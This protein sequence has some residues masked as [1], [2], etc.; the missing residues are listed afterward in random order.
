MVDIL[1]QLWEKFK[2]SLVSVLPVTFIILILAIT[3]FINLSSKEIV[4]FIITAILL[5]IGISLFNLGA[6]IALSPMGEYIGESLV[7]TKKII[8]LIV[9][10]FVMGVLTTIAEPDL[11]VLAEQVSKLVNN[12]VLIISVGIGVGVFLVF[13]ILK[14]VFKK[15][16]TQILMFF[17]MLLFA[18]C[19]LMAEFGKGSYIPLSFDS[20]GV[21]TGPITVPFLMALGLGVALSI[22]GKDKKNASFGIIALCSIG[23]IMAVAILMLTSN[24]DMKYTLD[25]YSLETYLNSFGEL[26]LEHIKDVA[27]SL[28]L[29]IVFFFV[30]NFTIIKLPKAKIFRILIG[31]LYTFVGLVIFLVSVNIG[32][33][34][35]GYKIGNELASNKVVLIIFAFLLGLVAVLAEPAVHV[36][37]KQVEET[38][39]GMITKTQMTIALSIGVGISICLSF[40]RILYGFSILYYII[41]GYIISL[42]LSLFVP[43]IYTSIAFDSGG[44]A[45]GP[46]TSS[47][48]LPMAIGACL[49]L[50]GEE[51]IMNFAFGLVAMVAMTPLIT[52]Q[53][54]GFRG[55]MRDRNKTRRTIRTIIS[56]DDNQ[57]I[58]F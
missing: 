13:A 15:D 36:L 4:V 58:Y 41:P 11:S 48:I 31:L 28:G 24:G 7:K 14:I 55:L 30:L 29:L 44:V 6:D 42:G 20:G 33:L 5:I 32:F 35:I 45:S 21:T 16:L 10:I 57:I 34:P 27:I 19:L 17:Y 40:I 9:V 49:A 53:I 51:H 25:N 1:S 54:L 56:K 2:E 38:T 46:L 23:P 37:N 8:I 52:I 18:F 22:G 47:F 50:Q 39:M 26:V 3:P 43:K 12:I